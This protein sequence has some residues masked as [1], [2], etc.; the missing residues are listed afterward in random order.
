MARET[1]ASTCGWSAG[2]GLVLQRTGCGRRDV[3]AK[4]SAVWRKAHARILRNMTYKLF[5]TSQP[6]VLSDGRGM[7]GLVTF[8]KSDPFLRSALQQPEI[9]ITI[10]STFV[11]DANN[12]VWELN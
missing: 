1:A 10:D 3:A 8:A 2:G 9:E 12:E 11:L 7:R 6:Y 5:V 4:L